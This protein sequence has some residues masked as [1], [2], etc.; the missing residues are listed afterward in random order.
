MEGFLLFFPPTEALRRI[1]VRFFI[2]SAYL[3]PLVF[4]LAV[5]PTLDDL[6]TISFKFRGSHHDTVARSKLGYTR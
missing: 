1:G 5:S 3:V 4:P 6:C 2:V